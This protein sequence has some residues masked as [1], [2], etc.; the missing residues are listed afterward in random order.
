MIRTLPLAV[1]LAL[2]P[3]AAL[4]DWS[5]PTWSPLLYEG[6]AIAYRAHAAA[7]EAGRAPDQATPEAATASDAGL[8]RPSLERRRKNLA[9]FVAKT[10][11]ADPAGADSL[12]ALF[13]QGDVIEQ[14]KPLVAKVGLDVNRVADAQALYWFAAWNAAHGDNPDPT[15]RQMAAIRAQAAQALAA[16]PAFATADDATRQNMAEALWIQVLLLDG[17]V[18]QA[19][20]DPAQ[21]KAV[22]VAAAQGARASGFDVQALK[23]T[24]A[25]F[26]R[27]GE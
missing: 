6:P 15:P 8:F 3:G 10:R 19:K 2:A 27:V 9:D 17:A 18:E 4:A 26:A 1:L 20:A 16:T 14:M 23:L 5:P 13:A 11:R 21:L 25:G 12:A 22:G 7:Q 24:D